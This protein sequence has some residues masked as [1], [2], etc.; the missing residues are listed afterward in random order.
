MRIEVIKNKDEAQK[1]QGDILENFIEELMDVLGYKVIRNVRFTSCELDLLCKNKVSEKEIYVECKAYNEGT[2][3]ADLLKKMLGT[4]DFNQYS[5]GWF[6]T[7]GTLSKDAKGFVETWEKRDDR[8]KLLIYTP[9]RIVDAMVDARIIQRPPTLSPREL[10]LNDDM[11][12]GE[13]N[14]ILSEYGK[15]WG[16]SILNNGIPISFCLC[17][18]SKGN[19][20]EDNNLIAKIKQTNLSFLVYPYWTEIPLDGKSN[21][22]TNCSVVE[23]EIGERWSDYRPAR[24]EHFVGRKK[25]IQAI[26]RFISQVKKRSTDTRVFAIKGESGIGKSSFVAKIRE[27]AKNHSKPNH[28]FLYA[29]DVRAAN[30]ASYIAA[31][32]LQCLKGAQKLGYG[33]KNKL[34]LTNV[35]NPLESDSIKIFLD[36]CNRKNE[37]IV[38]VL[39][40]FEELYSKPELSGI[41][42]AA[43]EL[44]FSVIAAKT[45]MIMG[46]AWKT[47]CSIPQDHPA[48]HMWH[49][50]QDHRFEVPLK[51]FSHSD[52]EQSLSMFE[53]EL[54]EKIRPT[55]K[56]YLLS[57]CQGLPWLLKK[58]CIHF[59]QQLSHGF[60]QIEIESSSL[61]IA[62]LFEKDLNSLSSK[63]LSC[64]KHIAKNTPA[65]W[66][67]TLDIFDGE[68][69][70]SLINKRLII[71]RGNKLNL[72][73]DIFKDYV[74]S[75]N[76]PEIPFNYIPQSTSLNGL[77]RVC[78]CLNS[79][80]GKDLDILAKE[81][82]L[83]KTTVRNIVH[84]L[85]QFGIVKNNTTLDNICL[86]D[87]IVNS[88]ERSFLRFLRSTFKRHQ[89]TIFLSH[90]R[91]QMPTT[92]EQTIDFLKQILPAAQHDRKTWE[93]YAKKMILW[94]DCLGYV[95]RNGDFYF[96]N[97]RDDIDINNKKV[98]GTRKRNGPIFEADA[99]PRQ[100]LDAFMFVL[101]KGEQPY[102]IM[103]RNKCRNACS[104]LIR[105]GMLSLVGYTFK[106]LLDNPSRLE[107][108]ENIFHSAEKEESVI[109]FITELKINPN[110]S[111][112]AIAEELARKYH[113]EWKTAS[114]R[115]IGNALK[116]WA[117][118]II[119]SRCSNQI[120]PPPGRRNN[121][122]NDDEQVFDF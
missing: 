85:I 28:I 118:W 15:Y 13:W 25:T 83:K 37:V 78:M 101:E 94:L 17:S 86:S 76:I 93:V 24:P 69:I 54:G 115:R 122:L 102:S 81:T 52:A 33:S 40:Q 91:N 20:V 84:D 29:V 65:D 27:D 105:F 63:E 7:T 22:E 55:L 34:T 31:S 88:D 75:G 9:D 38:L 19:V 82:G 60:S 49:E 95:S 32:L 50:L 117:S 70:Q 114:L 2:L 113:R 79:S 53:A 41:F 39:D 97:D 3:S 48:Y 21:K 90:E 96:Y 87:S 26:F 57:N 71:K 10:M 74:N 1:Q 36:E 73:W 111:P 67:E 68:I 77:L 92:Y 56:K 108:I 45:C 80:T 44:M 58:L 100:L 89:L 35:Q 12:L 64:I 6:F 30:N 62:S 4:I 120:L 99:S 121:C 43:K 110:R 104:V 72:Y 59:E 42:N 61:D 23:V 106:P 46:F 51:Q 66:V 16:A 18:A 47:D 8:A 103:K 107:V 98:I 109:F 112:L 119:Q 5:E 14:L 11:E 116:I